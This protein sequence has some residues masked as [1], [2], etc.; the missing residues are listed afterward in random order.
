MRSNNLHS[1]NEESKGSPTDEN[2][3][4]LE[5]SQNVVR[6]TGSLMNIPDGHL[7]SSSFSTIN[8]NPMGP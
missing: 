4:N 2:D 1:E 8:D 6:R 7:K 5:K 3:C